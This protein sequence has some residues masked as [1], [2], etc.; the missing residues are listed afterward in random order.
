[1]KCENAFDHFK[2]LHARFKYENRES[3]SLFE[4]LS[5]RPFLVY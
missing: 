3:S 5:D 2:F 4:R 1:M